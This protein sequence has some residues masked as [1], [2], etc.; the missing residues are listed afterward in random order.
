MAEL[1]ERL[2]DSITLQ[3][4][5]FGDI[6]MANNIER[7]DDP[8]SSFFST[9]VGFASMH[10]AAEKELIVLEQRAKQLAFLTEKREE[11]KVLLQKKKLS[12]LSNDGKEKVPPPESPPSLSPSGARRSLAVASSPT[13][14]RQHVDICQVF[15]ERML[16][17]N[18]DDD[19][20]SDE[21]W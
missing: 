17:L 13:T 15:K 12:A 21:E 2:D 18:G 3:R 19:S 5:Y 14:P 10:Q 8:W 7:D 20:G 16:A 9:V 4:R 1:V 11:Q 6:L